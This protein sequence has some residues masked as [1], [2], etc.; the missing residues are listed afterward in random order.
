MIRARKG[1]YMLWV[2]SL[3]IMASMGILWAVLRASDDPLELAIKEAQAWDRQ[4]QRL[5]KVLG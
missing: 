3:G 4:Q 1:A 2:I 5:R